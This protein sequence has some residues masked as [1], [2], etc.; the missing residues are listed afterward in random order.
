MNNSAHLD[1]LIYVILMLIT[2]SYDSYLEPEYQR[3]HVRGEK[4]SHIGTKTTAYF[5][6]YTGRRYF[7]SHTA[8][9]CQISF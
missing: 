7:I 3:S 1:S 9:I 5:I 4:L 6:S 8:R 2:V